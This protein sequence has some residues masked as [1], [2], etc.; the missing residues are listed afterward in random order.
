M[1]RHARIHAKEND[2][3]GSGGVKPIRPKPKT[4]NWKS[5]IPISNSSTPATSLTI[6]PGTSLLSSEL[7][8]SMPKFSI[9]ETKSSTP[10]LTPSE[11]VSAG[12]KRAFNFVEYSPTQFTSPPK[13]INLFQM[14]SPPAQVLTE[15]TEKSSPSHVTRA[16][17]PTS[18]TKKPKDSRTEIKSFSNS[19][20]HDRKGHSEVEKATSSCDIFVIYLNYYSKN[21]C[22]TILTYKTAWEYI[23]HIRKCI[24]IDKIA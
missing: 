19:A 3:A 20:H 23:Y 1:H 15:V 16:V 5:R 6:S 9:L 11:P 8:S 2:L 17:G 4:P 12:Q 13:K 18:I 22:M 7:L 21:I 24:S 14:T 10:I